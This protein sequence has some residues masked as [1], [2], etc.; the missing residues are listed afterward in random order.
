MVSKSTSVLNNNEHSITDN[1][2]KSK[3]DSKSKRP[4]EISTSDKIEETFKTLDQ[5]II[6]ME[7]EYE[8]IITVHNIHGISPYVHASAYSNIIR[9]F[10]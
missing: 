6:D 4:S 8:N 10:E 1:N 9:I 5:K 2:N 7:A 3:I